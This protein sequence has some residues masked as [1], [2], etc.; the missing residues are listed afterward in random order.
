MTETRPEITQI[1]TSAELRRWY[2]YRSELESD[3][4]RRK[5][6]TAGGKFTLLERIAHFL[7]T[8]ERTW[9]GDKTVPTKSKFDWHGA[10]LSLE[11]VIT[12][13][14]RNS[15][16]VR[17]FFKSQL[18]DDFKFNIPFMAWMK[19]NVGATLAEA[20]TTYEEMK[21]L[22]F[23]S[24]IPDHNQFNKYQ[25]DFLADNPDMGL[26]EV[27]KYWFLKIKMPSET[28]RHEYHRSDL[29]LSA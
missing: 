25:R 17:R 10:P 2:W 14:Y 7:D 12:D 9:P 15:Q 28:G 11:T 19:E 26:E 23:P 24:E 27:R 1:T 5:L 22:G 6:K 8:G 29:T 16:N 13:S 21:A 20:C 3:C 18:G 4:K